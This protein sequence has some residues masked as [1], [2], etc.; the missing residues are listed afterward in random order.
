MYL[1]HREA[2]GAYFARRTL[3]G[4]V[5][6]LV[7]ETFVVAWRKPPKDLDEPLPWLYGVA[8]RVLASH[9]RASGRREALNHRLVH[10]HRDA[11][12]IAPHDT[13]GDE[14]HDPQLVAALGALTEPQQEALRLVAWEELTGAQAARAAGCPA[15]VFAARLARAR[16]A[17]RSQLAALAPAPTAAPAAKEPT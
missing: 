2:L 10:T 11:A 12:A 5:D 6:D 13:F 14:L 1:S 8:R 9:R 4:D 15:P 17:L 16:R 7:T 3:H